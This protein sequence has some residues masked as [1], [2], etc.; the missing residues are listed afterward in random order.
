MDG[1][2]YALNPGAILRKMFPKQLKSPLMII[3]WTVI[4]CLNIVVVVLVQ[5]NCIYNITDF[6]KEALQEQSY[7][8][9]CEIISVVKYKDYYV[10]YQNSEGE[11]RVAH[12]EMF[13]RGIFERAKIDKS[14]D[15]LAK[16]DGSIDTVSNTLSDALWTGNAMAKLVGIYVGL[17]V[18]MLLIEFYLYGV[19][20][21]LFRE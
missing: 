7:F 5:N 9:N 12:L 16:E 13:P 15:C 19:F 3:I 2:Y 10:T 4:L 17:G 6:S 20:H 18:L 8:K 1:L 21:R 11:K 14:Y